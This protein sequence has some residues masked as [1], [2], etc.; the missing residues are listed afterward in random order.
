MMHDM[1][2]HRHHY[3]S[4]NTDIKRTR[5]RAMRTQIHNTHTLS[6]DTHMQARAHTNIHTNTQTFV[7]TTPSPSEQT[8]ANT[9][10]TCIVYFSEENF[11]A[12]C[13]IQG[14]THDA[15]TNIRRSWPFVLGQKL[16][17]STKI[18]Q[19]VICAMR[20]RRHS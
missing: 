12:F 11:V 16:V 7:N 13:V 9:Q 5:I 8:S 18:T 19:H 17:I 4:S 10:Q 2:I 1:R 15:H 20:I 14:D 3:I 6:A